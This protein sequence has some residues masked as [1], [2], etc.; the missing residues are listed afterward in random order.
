MTFAFRCRRST[1][2]S[3]AA[4]SV[5]LAGAAA[6][7]DDGSSFRNE[8]SGFSN[9]TGGGDLS[10][11]NRRS[12]LFAEAEVEVSPQ[13]T[14]GDGTV[15]AARAVFNANDG[16]GT[17][18]SAA[19][20]AIPE[21]SLFVIGEFGR[22]EIGARAGFPQSLIGYA[23]SEIAFTAAEFGPDS[24][25]RLDPN[26]QLPARFLPG[27]TAARLDA[28]TYLGYSE[29]WYSDESPKVIYLTPRVQLGYSGGIYAAFSYTPQSIRGGGLEI[30]PTMQ[31][32]PAGNPRDL[33]Q[34]ALVYNERG[35]DVDLST[36]FT[37]SHAHIG[38][39]PTFARGDTNSF[40]FG[41]SASIEDTWQF[42]ASGTWD[43]ASSSRP[44]LGRL[45]GDPY[46][47]V[48]SVNYLEGP[49]I[50][51][52]YWQ[53]ATAPEELALATRDRAE[54]EEIGVSYL[55]NR[56]HDFL[57]SERY[58]DLKLY[59]GLYHFDLRS[60]TLDSTAGERGYVLLAGLRLSFY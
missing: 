2:M 27:S 3:I 26:G 60:E 35:E 15:F 45:S 19:T 51:G 50:V 13:Y 20:A 9:V 54:I 39:G 56:R 23:P 22:I 30:V 52:G 28:L 31:A 12:G 42:G 16:A 47:V 46:G 41:A 4:G 14:A 18:D 57:G 53:Y 49:W 6:A 37:W 58:A 34:G 1:L 25:F 21:A 10:S 59:S 55:I 33:A 5:L 7:Q 24:G 17:F 48:A 36:G 38:D 43:G 44:D 32:T 29:R 8:I 40:A 11:G